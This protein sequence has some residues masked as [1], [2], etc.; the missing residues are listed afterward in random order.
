[1]LLEEL[2]QCFLLQDYAG[3]RS[4]SYYM[5]RWLGMGSYHLCGLPTSL[6]PHESAND[7]IRALVL[8]QQKFETGIVQREPHW[9]VDYPA[10]AQDYLRDSSL[11][12]SGT[13]AS[14]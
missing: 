3:G 9:E 7:R 1:V 14:A 11:D 4:Y 10:L 6:L 8:S 12:P 2:V 5:K 13:T